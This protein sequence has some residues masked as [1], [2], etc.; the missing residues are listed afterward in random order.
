[1]MFVRKFEAV[2]RLT[3]NSLITLGPFDSYGECYDQVILYTAES[4][5]IETVI[6]FMINETFINEALKGG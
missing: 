4:L 5:P 2:V 3:D 1:M 6:G